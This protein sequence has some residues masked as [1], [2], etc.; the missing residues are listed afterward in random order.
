MELEA[1]SR[2]ALADLEDVGLVHVPEQRDRARAAPRADPAGTVV[3][4]GSSAGLWGLGTYERNQVLPHLASPR[5]TIVMGVSSIWVDAGPWV[6][7]YMARANY[8]SS[9]YET[10]SIAMRSY[11]S[12]D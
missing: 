1:V 12:G 8:H 6:N 4:A 10:T 7:S 3:L 2:A 11:Q 9:I 5:R